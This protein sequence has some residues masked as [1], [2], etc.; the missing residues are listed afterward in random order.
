VVDLLPLWPSWLSWLSRQA[1]LFSVAVLL[2]A[3]LRIPVRKLLGAQAAY[4]CW[5][6]VPAAVLGA[7]LQPLLSLPTFV[8]G[9]G[10]LATL[11]LLAENTWPGPVLPTAA[12][13]GDSAVMGIVSGA[14]LLVWAFS[15]LLLTVLLVRSQQR[16]NRQLLRGAPGQPAWL[17]AGQGPAVVGVWRPFIALPL[18]FESRFDAAEQ[19]AMLAHEAAHLLRHDTRWNL[20]ACGLVVWHGLNPLAWWAWRRMRADQE[21][22]CDAAVLG[23]MPGAGL[24]SAPQ[25]EIA[26]YARALLK[27]PTPSAWTEPLPCATPWSSSHPLVERIS[28]LRQHRTS[29]SRRWAGRALA[30]GAVLAALGAGQTLRANSDTATEKPIGVWLEI[31]V[32][33][34]GQ[35]LGSPRLFGKLNEK[36]TVSQAPT[37]A[38]AA[39]RSWQLEV[40]A[41]PAPQAGQLLIETRLSTGQPLQ[42]VAEPGLIADEGKAVRIEQRSANGGVL[43]I[44]M[45]ARRASGP[46]PAPR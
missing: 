23:A 26:A 36:M 29:P 20:L 22:A 44:S 1:L 9:W 24:R 10:P 40:T 2:V 30:A 38:D 41:S 21:L 37:G 11:T 32:D 12:P 16:F 5:A 34:D 3:L 7:A 43:G 6:V 42:L 19:Q 13:R 39:A 25:V 15:A 18:D 35:P 17:P 14:L 33:R 27:S 28:M 4:L 45:T 31:T 46:L 8:V